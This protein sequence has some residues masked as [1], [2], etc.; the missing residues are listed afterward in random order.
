VHFSSPF[1]NV[2]DAPVVE[3]A[4][5]YVGPDADLKEVEAAAVKFLAFLKANAK[6][7]LGISSGW[8]S[9]DID[10]PRGEG[11]MKAIVGALGWESLEAHMASA[12]SDA[13][14]E[15]IGP[16]VAVVEEIEIVS[17]L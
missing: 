13:M 15:A 9:E 12:Q 10:S 8:T 2:S 16:L 17:Y 1:S 3:L 6:G 11:K 14:K 7:I 4:T 5:C